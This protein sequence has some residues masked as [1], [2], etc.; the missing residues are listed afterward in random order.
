MH[1]ILLL[2]NHLTKNLHFYNN[3]KSQKRHFRIFCI[4]NGA[5][6]KMKN[7][8][9]Y[10]FVVFCWF[11]LI[12]HLGGYTMHKWRIYELI[13]TCFVKIFFFWK[14]HIFPHYKKGLFPLFFYTPVHPLISLKLM[15][16]NFKV[17]SMNK[18]RVCNIG[19]LCRTIIAFLGQASGSWVSLPGVALYR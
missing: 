11:F 6:L 14:F 2:M 3:K 13:W 8:K 17:N 12:D 16:K 10:F 1:S 5:T 9:M 15:I 7:L 18:N 19:Q 4:N